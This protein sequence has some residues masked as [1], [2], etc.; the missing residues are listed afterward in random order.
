MPIRLTIPTQ[1]GLKENAEVDLTFLELGD[2]YT[3]VTVG[4]I[5]FTFDMQSGLLPQITRDYLDAQF[6]QYDGVT[7][8]IWQPSDNFPTA[9]YTVLRW[10]WTQVS[11]Q[12]YILNATFEQS[13][14]IDCTDI[15]LELNTT[16][17]LPQL[18][19]AWDFIKRFTRDAAPNFSNSIKLSLNA[20]HQEDGRR[21]YFPSVCG[22]TEGTFL[23]SETLLNYYKLTNNT[24]VKSYALDMIDSAVSV[25]YRG[26][27]IPTNP[28]AKVWLPHWLYTAR[29]QA[30]IKGATSSPNFLQSGYFDQSITFTNGVG[31]LP[32][33]LSDCYKIYTGTLLWKFVYSPA[34]DGTTET[35][36]YWIDKHNFKVFPS[37]DRTS[38]NTSYTAGTVVLTTAVSGTRKAVY[39][40]YTG[41]YVP[42]NACIEA[43]PMWRAC[44]T[45][46]YLE[47]NHALD[48]SYWAAK[49]YKALYDV[50]ADEKWNRALSATRWST[51]QASNVQN[52]S[53]VIKKD[54]GTNDPFSYAGTQ[55]VKING[56]EGNV[57]RQTTGDFVGGLVV[58]HSSSVA[59]TYGQLELQNFAV[60]AIWVRATVQFSE[61]KCSIATILYFGVSLSDD[62]RDI[63]KMYY[64]P[65]MCSANVAYTKS[66]AL[67]DFKQWSTK[68][69]WHSTNADAPL[70]SYSGSGG[71]AIASQVMAIYQ[72]RETLVGRLQLTPGS[73]Y[74]G[75]GFGYMQPTVRLSKLVYKMT[76]SI[77]LIITDA[78]SNT[79]QY[80][81]LAATDWTELE[82]SWDMFTSTTAP[83]VV[84]PITGV[85][86]QANYGNADLYC[87]YY[88]AKPSTLPP[89]SYVYK[90]VIGNRAAA[91]CTWVIGTIRV[92]NSPLNILPYSPGVVPFTANYVGDSRVSW[93]GSPY[94]GYC[95]EMMW[96]MF[97]YPQY[98]QQVLE[99][100]K[101]AQDSY[102]K[103]SPTGANWAMRQVYNWARWDAITRPPYNR[104]VDEGADPNIAWEGYAHRAI[105]TTAEYWY[106]NPNDFL[107]QQV[108]MRFLTG[109]YGELQKRKALGQTV[110]TP[111]DYP[112]PQNGL[113]Q[114][115]YR[116]PHGDGLILRTAI[117]ANLAGGD[118]LVTM[119]LIIDLWASLNAQYISTGL[120]SGSW[121]GLQDNW[122]SA[123]DGQNVKKYY[124]FWHAEIMHALML[125]NEKKALLR[126][127]ACDVWAGS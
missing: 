51:V 69:F 90:H 83:N 73:G 48:V 98:A 117:Y 17:L 42:N 26:V 104:F 88:G 123:T 102:A 11:V 65:Y 3:Q 110:C 8:F 10:S 32:S 119:R 77:D 9:L 46:S 97:G 24:E 95:S 5:K 72:D 126:Y 70:Y 79:H 36:A 62:P 89:S 61:F 93:T 101:A 28:S 115:N 81:L 7:E 43:F 120:M 87:Y 127:P 16:N 33:S 106:N 99:F 125:L 20:F 59:S 71:S 56:K 6:R 118:R 25:L 121:A 12:S 112:P 66:F 29:G 2:S 124:P 96:M 105:E 41:T 111:S 54:T 21:N 75:G 107:A 85:Q 64:M 40:L 30:E 63:S 14:S 76:G 68:T 52:E 1:V 78:N 50:T 114:W 58:N 35:I 92:D 122:Y 39:A 82:L 15:V 109:L 45:G 55:L 38:N 44:L 34:I 100:K 91:A 116:T 4:E 94:T 49:A 47:I 108:T 13:K 86:F 74:A 67:T 18:S 23:I 103:D 27:A 113:P 60:Q 31:T 80:K 19:A 22:T 57:T 53:Y 84:D 37:G